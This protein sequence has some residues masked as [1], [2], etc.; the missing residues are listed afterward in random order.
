[1]IQYETDGGRTLPLGGEGFA[2]IGFG[3][4]SPP[5]SSLLS[6]FSTFSPSSFSPF[7]AFSPSSPAG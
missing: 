6:F 2:G 1:M 3:L 7:S 5:P 4:S